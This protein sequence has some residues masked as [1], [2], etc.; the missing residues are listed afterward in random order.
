MAC[1]LTS[2]SYTS[3]SRCCDPAPA[4]RDQLIWWRFSWHTLRLSGASQ[5]RW[6]KGCQENCD[7]MSEWGWRHRGCQ[8][9][10]DIM[11]E[12]GWGHRGLTGPPKRSAPGSGWAWGWARP[13]QVLAAPCR[14]RRSAT[15]NL[16]LLARNMLRCEHCETQHT[17]FAETQ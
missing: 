6:Q 10:C 17:L 1:V 13:G 5:A 8:E 14:I 15:S 9:N 3:L 4:A 7:I 2:S 11:S 12:W 16:R